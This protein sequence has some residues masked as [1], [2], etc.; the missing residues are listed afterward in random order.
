MVLIDT[1]AV[2]TSQDMMAINYNNLFVHNIN[3]TKNIISR[4]DII[5]TFINANMNGNI[6]TPAAI[7]QLDDILARL[8]QM[9]AT[10]ADQAKI[11]TKLKKQINNI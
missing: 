8:S 2:N 6:P 4:V 1:L 10:I 11:I 3:A 7:N 5:E 9:E